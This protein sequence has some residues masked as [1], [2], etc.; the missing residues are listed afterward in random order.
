MRDL[1]LAAVM[2]IIGLSLMSS[3]N[4]VNASGAQYVVGWIAFVIA[5]GFVANYV[6]ER[7][8]P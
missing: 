2:A 7:T 4:P 8:E 1:I 6:M 5:I 3:N